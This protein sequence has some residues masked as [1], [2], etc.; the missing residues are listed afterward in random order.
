MT[1]ALIPRVFK[2]ALQRE[3]AAFIFHL[4]PRRS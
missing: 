4:H 2:R 3:V 1:S